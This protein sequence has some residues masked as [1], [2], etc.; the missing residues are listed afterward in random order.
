MENR[1]PSC[2]V[3]KWRIKFIKFNRAFLECTE[4]GFMKMHP[5]P[6][7]EEINR[8]YNRSYYQRWGM[9]EGESE[10]IRRMKAQTAELLLKRVER[11]IRPGKLLDVGCAAGHF[12]EAAANR[13]WDVWGV[14]ISEYSAAL[15][16]SKFGERIINGSFLDA[17][18][19]ENF[20]DCLLMSDV[21]EHL[22]DPHPALE[23]TCRLLRPGGLLVVVTPDTSALIS[24]IFGQYWITF[25]EEHLIYF[26]RHNIKIF[27]KRY[28]FEILCLAIAV[29]VFNL[30]YMKAQLSVNYTPIVTPLFRLIN[31]LV[32]LS[33]RDMNLP[34]FTGDM[35]VIA[36]RG[37]KNG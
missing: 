24:K 2:N 5:V 25:Q 34:F 22:S 33:W 21:L 9:E 14:E 27:L 12:M 17:N 8:L 3:I 10:P 19:R 32:P 7:R 6:T 31:H 16:K 18:L 1:C 11:F 23:K 37:E 29:K 36:K 4:C 13:G 20:F 26:N 28:A 35:C 15:A 30:N